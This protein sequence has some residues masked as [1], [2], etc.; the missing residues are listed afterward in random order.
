MGS[1][2]GVLWFDGSNRWHKY[3]GHNLI[4]VAGGR[5]ILLEEGLMHA[6]DV[7]TGRTLWET[8]VPIGV[9][10]L[11]QAHARDAI[12]LQR[13]RRWSPPASLS[14]ATELVAL[15]DAIYISDGTACL[16]FDAATGE[17]AGRIELPGDAEEAWANL[18]VEDDYL[19]GTSGA[20]LFCMERHSGEV[21]WER[22]L[23]D[24]DVSVAVGAGKVFCAETANLRRGED[25]TSDG[26]TRALD[27]A[28][29]EVQWERDGGAPLR[30]NSAQE[31]LITPVGFYCA[32]EGGLVEQPVDPQEQRLIVEG[33]DRPEHGA[34]GFVTSARMLTGSE[35]SLFAYEL[36]SGELL[37]D[38]P[39]EWVRRGCTDT[40][41]SE[42]LLTTRYRSNSAWIDLE[43]QEIT[44]FLA[45]RPGCTV[46]NNLYPANGVLNMPNLT[47]GCTCNFI[48]NS[49]ATV[50]SDEIRR[51]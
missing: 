4:R 3:P 29:G 32:S 12:R 23:D 35:Q 27:L 41:A 22:E 49:L 26:V 24:R 7:Y 25:E 10:P 34:P 5:R 36:P 37:T 46:N 1:D 48:P 20:Y 38:D 9:E 40:R 33:R 47:G 21:V 45:V 43:T 51:N 13:Q 17:R 39:L 2:L 44:P 28:T 15:E 31:M 6:S 19:V 16:V 14:E 8:E 18:R 50:S 42:R 11:A 30:Y